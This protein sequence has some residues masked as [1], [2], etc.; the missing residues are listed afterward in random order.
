MASSLPFSEARAPARISSS[1][2]LASNRI[3]SPRLRIFLVRVP[4]LSEQRIST[5]ASS[6]MASSRETIAFFFARP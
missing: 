5:P 2:V 6:S 4:V 3:G 1:A